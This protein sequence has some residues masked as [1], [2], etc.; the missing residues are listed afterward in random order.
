MDAIRISLTGTGIVLLLMGSTE[1]LF[2]LG[3]GERR[4]AALMKAFVLLYGLLLIGLGFS[5]AAMRSTFHGQGLFLTIVA[6]A[7]AG[8]FLVVFP[9][10]MR[11]ALLAMIEGLGRKYAAALVLADALLRTALAVAFIYIAWR[12]G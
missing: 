12:A 5:I 2:A 3:S 10:R 4:N 9:G 8:P 11:A 6:L 7:V 1:V